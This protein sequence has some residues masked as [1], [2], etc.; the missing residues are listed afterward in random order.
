M[1]IHKEGTTSILV[2]LTLA[3]ILSV[4][5][6]F[7]SPCIYLSSLLYATY[8]ILFLFI[9]LFFRYPNRTIRKEDNLVIAPA[10]G[11][12]VVIEEIEEPEYFKDK[13]IQ[14]SIFMS[15]LNVHS[16]HYP[17]SGEIIYN[18]YH[19]GKH[20]VASHPKSSTLNERHS[21]VIR[22]AS[23]KEILVKQVAGTVARRIVCYAQNGNQAEQGENYG[24]IKFGSRVDVI[25]PLDAQIEVDL[26]QTT[27]NRQSVI[28][29]LN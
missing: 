22:H 9:L 29:K 1:T 16:N 19:A 27:K 3:L 14:V 2:A 15:P 8:G 5:T 4:V 28:A 12:V 25:L 24:F 10:D 23:G 26:G 11:K 7:L 21:V 13:R 20:M 17:V 18:R 6:Y